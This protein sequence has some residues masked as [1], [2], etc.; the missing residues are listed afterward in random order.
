MTEQ[1]TP[2]SLVLPP[3]L[4]RLRLP[5]AAA[6]TALAARIAPHLAP[7]DILLLSGDLGAGKTHFARGLI[8]ARLAAE[9][10]MEE[11]PSP[12]FTL[13]QTYEAG[14]LEIWHCDLYRLTGADEVR[15]LGL[16]EA[17]ERAACLVEWPERMGADWPSGAVWLVF[18]A[19]PD[20]EDARVLTLHGRP[21][22]E[23]AKRLAP[24][25]GAGP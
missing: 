22:S 8:Q 16:D 3:R 5:D 1:P 20:D 25:I 24:L 13:V 11:V 18:S 10:V 7:G 14:P 4:A 9:G 15:E 12:S 21:E 6:T 17:M 2:P 19:D 23:T